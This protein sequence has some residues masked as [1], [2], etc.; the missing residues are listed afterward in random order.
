MDRKYLLSVLV[1]VLSAAAIAFIIKLI[2]Y[3]MYPYDLK[4]LSEIVEMRNVDVYRQFL[5]KQPVGSFVMI[6]LS[7]GVGLLGGLFISRL[8]FN[9]A[10]MGLYIITAIILLTNAVNF[11]SVPNP[12]WFPFAD[13]GFTLLIAFVYIS[14]RK[15]A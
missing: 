10:L 4:E 3:R 15:K 12:T 1:G 7:H 8:I 9:R 13:I 5:L 14:S 11:L 2:S 6:I